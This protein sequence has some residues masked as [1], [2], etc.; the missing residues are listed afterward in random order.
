[1][2]GCAVKAKVV[3]AVSAYYLV[4][5]MAGQDVIPV[6]QEYQDSLVPSIRHEQTV[7]NGVQRSVIGAGES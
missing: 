6:Q 2:A 1:L 4:R 3:K 7:P 5:A